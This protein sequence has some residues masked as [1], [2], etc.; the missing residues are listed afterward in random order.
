[1]THALHKGKPTRKDIPTVA[2]LSAVE[3][4]HDFAK[5]G[6]YGSRPPELLM[7]VFGCCEKVALAAIER[8]MGRYLECGVS[9]SLAWL[10]P[11]GEEK[12]AE[13]RNPKSLLNSEDDSATSSEVTSEKGTT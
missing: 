1:M 8:E 11:E 2:V 6:Q 12:L 13:L 3:T 7:A 10:T 5:Q 9:T 4:Y